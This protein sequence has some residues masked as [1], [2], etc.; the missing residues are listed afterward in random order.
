MEKFGML[1]LGAFVGGILNYGLLHI[2]DGPGFKE[3]V[4]VVFGAAFSGVVF[5]FL[6]FLINLKEEGA[7]ISSA[8]RQAIYVYP[9]GLILALLWAQIPKTLDERITNPERGKRIVG[10]LH[11]V[12]LS[13][14]SVVIVVEMLRDTGF[15]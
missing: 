10:W 1:C 14:L 8:D 2:K 7:A 12:T 3:H 13:L 15:I 9:V 4:T 5:V 6:Q 11:L